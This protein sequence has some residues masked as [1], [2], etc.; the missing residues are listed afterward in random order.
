MRTIIPY[1]KHQYEADRMTRY[2]GCTKQTYTYEDL[3][4][5][6]DRWHRKQGFRKIE[7]DEY[8]DV[9][10]GYLLGSNANIMTRRYT[11]N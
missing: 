1:D 3:L 11:I 8:C 9:R 4:F 10:D 7:W 5:Y 6:Y 2:S